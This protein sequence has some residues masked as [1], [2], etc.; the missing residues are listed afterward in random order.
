MFRFPRFRIAAAAMLGAG[1][2]PA[3]AQPAST[4]LVALI[5]A[6]RAAPGSCAGQPAAPVAPLDAAS[7]LSQLRIGTGTFLEPALERAG[8][9]VE[10][11]EALFVSGAAE[12]EEAM[13]TLREKYCMRLLS[14]DITAAGAIRVADGWHVVLARPEPP[15][16][17]PDAATLG[18]ETLA[19][20][21]AARAVPRRCGDQQFAAA[22]PLQR[23]P[24]LDTAALAHSEDMARLRYF[25]H[26]EKNGSV[27]GDRA[28]K[29]GYAWRVIGENIASGQRTAQEA[30]DGWLDSPGHCANIMNAAFAEMGIGY[31]VNPQRGTLYWTQVLGRAR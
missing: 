20:V 6:Y 2:L 15:R 8:Y 18:A 25:S 27:V 23:N 24:A 9:P 11:A 28:R 5:N 16:H 22:P 3:S 7:A 29:A 4:D 30:V 21:N 10:H 31:A 13:R 14:T 1:A 17:L 26:V 12:P 19:A